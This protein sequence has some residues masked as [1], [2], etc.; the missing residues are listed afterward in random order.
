MSTTQDV[1]GK[2]SSKRKHGARFLI[3]TL[4]MCV[5]YFLLLILAWAL[6]AP[7]FEFPTQ[8]LSITGGIGTTLL[9]VTVFEKKV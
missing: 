8:L 1:N 2:E 3:I 5:I 6:G 4:A 9:G 7:L